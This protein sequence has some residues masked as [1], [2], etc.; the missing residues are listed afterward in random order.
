[1][2]I[3]H[4]FD[5]ENLGQR[6]HA[7]VAVPPASAVPTASFTRPADTTAYAVGDLI[8]NSTTAGSVVPMQL[9]CAR[10]KGGSGQIVRLR[11]KKSTASLT[12]A[13]FRVHL[14][15]TAPTPTNGDNGAWLTSGALTYLGAFDVTMDRAF[16]DG[17]AGAGVPLTG[18]VLVF[19]ADPASTVLHA[20][21]EA[22]AAYAGGA[23]EVFTVAAETVRD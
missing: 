10:R 13:S 15:R 7:V 11:L 23:S 6:M 20:L 22:R 1:M 2:P 21:V 4:G 9:E 19:V 18:P 17:A 5:D 14:Y 16:S 3:N 12:N 8:A